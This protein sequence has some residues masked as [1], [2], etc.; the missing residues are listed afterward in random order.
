ME[1][2]EALAFLNSLVN[3]ERLPQQGGLRE[4]RL[5]RMQQVLQALGNPHD[6]LR[7]IHVAGTK[8]K[9]SVS[10]MLYTV[11]AQC[12]VRTGL[13]TSP[14]LD[15]VLERVRVTPSDGESDWIA[16]GEFAEGMRRV[17]QAI[18]ATELTGGPLTYFEAL[19][20]LAFDYFARCGVQ[21]A[22]LEV[23]LGGRLDATNVAQAPLAVLTPISLDHTDVLGDTIEVIAAE[24]AAIIKPQQIVVTAPQRESVRAVIRARARSVGAQLIEQGTHVVLE[25][26]E[27]SRHGC[28]CW[29]RGQHGTYPTLELSL[30][31]RHQAENAT[32][33]LAVLE[34][35]QRL[36][37]SVRI[38]A[39]ELRT[40]LARVEWPGRGE[41]LTTSPPILLDGAHNRASAEALRAMINELFPSTR[42][43]LVIGMSLGK[44]V[45]GVME[46]LGP[47]AGAA[48]AV[49]AQHPRAMPAT[50][51]AAAVRPW[52]PRVHVTP[53]IEVALAEAHAAPCGLLVV[54]GSLFVIGEARRHVTAL[55]R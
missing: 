53:Q 33:A 50:T 21:W 46:T 16:E 9:G 52:I 30:L 32:T 38:T 1:F 29:I 51:L 4:R 27:V 41:L 54:T 48:W 44:D 12:G 5:A 28:T 13:F 37:P 35:L 2:P 3:Y 25:R 10:A 47:L 8:G 17:R 43:G 34:A 36:E 31:G 20:A 14:H 24:K 26:C 7:V 55:A 40:G 45:V 22:I 11:L 23:G 49:Q 39:S 6:H 15:S 19:T 18:E 42:V